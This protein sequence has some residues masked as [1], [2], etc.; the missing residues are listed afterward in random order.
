MAPDA[1]T[2]LA[3]RVAIVTGAGQGIGRVFARALA[4]A[5]AIPVI[6]ELNAERGQAVAAEIAAAAAGAGARV[7]PVATDVADPKSVASMVAAVEAA[8]GRIDI[9][10]NNAGIFSTLKTRPFY[11]IPLE[12]WEQVKTSRRSA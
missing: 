4:K 11:E 9:L 6:A 12:E 2:G 5:G 3:G 10:V 7:L 1:G 8:F